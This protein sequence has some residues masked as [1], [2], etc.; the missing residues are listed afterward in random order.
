MTNW[1]AT[2]IQ[3]AQTDA[4]QETFRRE[5]LRRKDRATFEAATWRRVSFCGNQYDRLPALAADASRP[6]GGRVAATGG[7]AS[8]LACSRRRP[9]LFQSCLRL[10]ATRPGGHVASLNRPGGTLTGRPSGNMELVPK[11][12]ELLH[13]FVPHWTMIALL[14]NRDIVIKRAETKYCFSRRRAPLV[15]QLYFIKASTESEIYEHRDFAQ[16][17]GS[18]RGCLILA[19]YGF[20]E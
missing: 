1:S 17:N 2:K 5:G 16:R 10:L 19:T 15:A 6:P 13:E 20:S 12:L 11:R 14:T 9:P 7:A 3:T 8:V 18:V 4:P